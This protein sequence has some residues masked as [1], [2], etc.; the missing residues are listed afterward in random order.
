[1]L[2]RSV[3]ENRKKRFEDWKNYETLGVRG[4]IANTLKED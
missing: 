1:M 2:T 3:E 4:I